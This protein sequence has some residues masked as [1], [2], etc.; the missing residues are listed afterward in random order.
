LLTIG[1][2]GHLVP[3]VSLSV[4]LGGWQLHPYDALLNRRNNCPLELYH[5]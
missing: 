2:R 3:Y 1:A 5:W 4:P